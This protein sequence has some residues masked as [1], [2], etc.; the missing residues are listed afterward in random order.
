MATL[1]SQGANHR[2]SVSKR[3]F[4]PREDRKLGNRYELLEPLGDGSHG[5][6]WRAMRAEDSKI[7]AVKIPR[8][9]GESTEYLKEGT[10]L[11][12][13]LPHPNVVAIYWMDWVPPTREYFAIEM[14]YF[15]SSTLAELL[16]SSAGGFVK[17]YAKLLGLFEQVLAGV[18]YLH[19][20]EMCHGD[21]KP[22]NILVSGDTAKITDFGSSVWPEDM[23]ART[24]ENGGTSLY[25]AP[26]LASTLRRGRSMQDLFLGD[27][28]SLGVLLYHIVTGD[29]PHDTLN[30][31]VSH[32]PFR[33]PRELN[34]S[35]CPAVEE[36][37]LRCMSQ[38]P[39][40]R[41]QTIDDLIEAASRA[42]KA[43]IDYV[44]EIFF[45]LDAA[46]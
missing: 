27:I 6:V 40:E 12:G 4:I 20:I 13:Q 36:I 44:P 5:T 39:E 43:Q 42:R 29:L 14:E 35:V 1:E 26:E 30:Q 28:Y 22:H 45:L 10:P 18:A 31:V 7:V 9:Q 32:A 41:Y 21:I 34:S 19:G 2:M 38:K 25:S 24:R 23:Y 33:R 8:A 15:P 16:D 17:S 11:I 46:I 3:F 37:I